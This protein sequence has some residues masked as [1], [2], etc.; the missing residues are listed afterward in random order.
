MNQRKQIEPAGWADFVNIQIKNQTIIIAAPVI[1]IKLFHKKSFA[2]PIAKM[3]Q[4]IPESIH[5]IGSIIWFG[6]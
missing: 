6:E 5:W 3:V 1:R 2:I 4:I